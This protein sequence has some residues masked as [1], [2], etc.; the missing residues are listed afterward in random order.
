M[1][2]DN[3]QIV[4]ENPEAKSGIHKMNVIRSQEFET[5]IESFFRSEAYLFEMDSEGGENE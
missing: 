1:N 2:W 4:A 5:P 3:V